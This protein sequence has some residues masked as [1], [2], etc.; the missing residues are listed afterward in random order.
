MLTL[1]QVWEETTQTGSD[2]WSHPWGPHCFELTTGDHYILLCAVANNSKRA[3]LVAVAQKDIRLHIATFGIRCV[4]PG[5]VY[6]A[7]L[8][9]TQDNEDYK[10]R[11]AI[12]N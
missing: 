4:R 2:R 9:P 10:D 6:E 7:L 8:W 11:V 5:I 12:F 1:R 3:G